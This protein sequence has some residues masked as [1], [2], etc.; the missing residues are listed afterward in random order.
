MRNDQRYLDMILKLPSFYY[1]TRYFLD[2]SMPNALLYVCMS[3][4]KPD[5]NFTYRQSCPMHHTQIKPNAKSLH[6][7]QK[8]ARSHFAQIVVPIIFLIAPSTQQ[9]QPTLPRHLSE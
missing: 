7:A 4:M 9:H 8:Q 6:R 3:I 5:T 1:A 2:E